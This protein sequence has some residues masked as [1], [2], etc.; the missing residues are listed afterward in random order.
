M[1]TKTISIFCNMMFMFFYLPPLLA[2]LS[3]EAVPLA[4]IYTPELSKLKTQ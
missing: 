3:V 2:P 4:I 1:E